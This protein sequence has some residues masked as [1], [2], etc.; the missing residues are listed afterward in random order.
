MQESFRNL[1]IHPCPVHKGQDEENI[2]I[3]EADWEVSWI[4]FINH[5]KYI[6]F[7]YMYLYYLYFKYI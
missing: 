6:L 4:D 5:L 2:L 7:K 3:E 1:S